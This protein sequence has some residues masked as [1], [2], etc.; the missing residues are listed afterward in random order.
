MRN[1]RGNLIATVIPASDGFYNKLMPNV[2]VKRLLNIEAL[3]GK[4]RRI[5]D[6]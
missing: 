3:H 4:P 2:K 5:F 6:S 1:R